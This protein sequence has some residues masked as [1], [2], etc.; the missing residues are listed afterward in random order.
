M[1]LIRGVQVIE[2]EDPVM[3]QG[4]F[5]ALVAMLFSTIAFSTDSMLPAFPQIAAEL[6]PDS[7]NRAVL[8]INLFLIGMGIGMLLTGPL[9]DTIGRKPV[10]YLGATLYIGGACLAW[11]AQSLEVVLIA[12]VIQGVGAAGPRIV[13][14]AIVR[15]LYSGREMAR[16]ISIAMMLFTLVPA[17]APV[18]GAWIV[19]ELGWRAIF[20][21]FIIF[22]V[23]SAL[24][25]GT[26]LDET[27][28]LEK[29][30]SLSFTKMRDAIREMLS[31]PVSRPAII[32]Q[33]LTTA[34]LFSALTMTQPIYDRVYGQADAFPFWFSAVAIATGISSLINARL[35]VIVGMRLLVKFAIV[36]QI[37]FS[38]S[39]LMLILFADYNTFPIFVF[40]Q[41]SVFCTAAF[42]VSNLNSIAMEPMGHIA[43]MAASVIGAVATIGGS[44]LA[45]PIALLFGGAQTPLIMLILVFSCSSFS[46]IYYI[47]RR[48]GPLKAS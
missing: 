11:M 32:V 16:M 4:E 47:G 2:N 39:A 3:G 33:T 21:S 31:H 14:L 12:R 42:C 25:L 38:L 22:S 13:S 1:V 19:T 44:L 5:I 27:L 48:A 29:R 9:S 34:G 24:W 28:C 36:A 18:M 35:V 37:L 6:T 23:V 40:W 45:A 46:I 17:V 10:V 7:P 8:I 41:F 30:R 26:R 20:G 43:G 15:D